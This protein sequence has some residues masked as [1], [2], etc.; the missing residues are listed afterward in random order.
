MARID[1]SA[2]KESRLEAEVT[3]GLGLVK[4]VIAVEAGSG[5]SPDPEVGIGKSHGPE[6]EIGR[7]PDPEAE[8]ESVEC[9]LVPDQDQDID[10]GVEAGAGPG[11]EVVIGRKELRN[12]GDLAEV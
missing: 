1:T 12:Q 11:V 4:G 5:R 3:Q 6:A 7:S 9:D 8:K 2:K 10:I